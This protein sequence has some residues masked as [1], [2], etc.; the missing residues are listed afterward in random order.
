[1]SEE[2]KNADRTCPRG[3][4]MAVGTSV[5][6]GFGYVIAL[7]FSVQVLIVGNLHCCFACCTSCMHACMQVASAQIFI[8]SGCVNDNF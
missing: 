8:C 7:L 2:T 5:V 1:M 4:M 3:I 6:L